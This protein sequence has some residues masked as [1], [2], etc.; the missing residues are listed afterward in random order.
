MGFERTFL[1]NQAKKQI[2]DNEKVLKR[3]YQQ[4]YDDGYKAGMYNEIEITYNLLAYTLTYKTGYSTKRIKQLLHDLYFNIDSFR[5]G[6]LSP[7][8][9]DTICA[10]LEKKGLVFGETMKDI[11]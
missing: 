1:R 7:N 3:C 11:D 8:D 6:Q 4:A 5:T 2:K 10:E 9:Y